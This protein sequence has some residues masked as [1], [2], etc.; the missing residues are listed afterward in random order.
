MSRPIGRCEFAPLF[1]SRRGTGRFLTG[2]LHICG[3]SVTKEEDVTGQGRSPVGA[4]MTKGWK[5]TPNT[6][7]SERSKLKRVF[8][9]RSSAPAMS[10]QRQYLP[11]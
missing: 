10:T 11:T 5:V 8:T 2:F 9:S 3:K 6:I 1:Q 7:S 4:Q